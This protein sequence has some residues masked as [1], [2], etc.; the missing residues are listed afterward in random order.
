MNRAPGLGAE[1]GTTFRSPRETAELLS[2][3]PS[4]L[5]RLAGIYSA[6]CG[7]LP[8]D[9]KTRSR[10]WPEEAVGE[11]LA[12][13]RLVQGNRASSIREA[14]EAIRRGEAETAEL[15]GESPSG[16]LAGRVDGLAD[17]VRELRRELATVGGL[18]AEIRGAI[19]DL[20]QRLDSLPAAVAD[21]R[22]GA[23]ESEL[24][25]LRRRLRYLQAEL[26]VREI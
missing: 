9:P 23:G 16:S 17:E 2:V 12:A 1:A 7:E 3:S 14:L 11:L 10:L 5:R 20:A 15:D 4:G 8:R 18:L 6:V 24:F 26:E 22:P 13:R 21:R 25:E 19:A